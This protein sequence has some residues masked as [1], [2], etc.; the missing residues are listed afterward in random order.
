MDEAEEAVKWLE[1][2]VEPSHKEI[3][4][5]RCVACYLYF[6]QAGVRFIHQREAH[7]IMDGWLK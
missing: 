5:E 6:N 2:Q 1:A 7:G 3:K 4:S